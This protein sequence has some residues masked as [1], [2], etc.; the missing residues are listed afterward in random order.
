MHGT[1]DAIA[2]CVH[3]TTAGTQRLKHWYALLAL[4]C[5]APHAMCPICVVP[6]FAADVADPFPQLMS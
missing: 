2:Q 1:M 5:M 4:P 3:S 6:V